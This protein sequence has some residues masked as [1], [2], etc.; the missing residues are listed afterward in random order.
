MARESGA[1]SLRRAQ[2][3]SHRVRRRGSLMRIE[4]SRTA[5]PA[6]HA[7]RGQ[8]VEG[9]EEGEPLGAPAG[10]RRR[11]AD[12]RRLRREVDSAGAG[13]CGP[14]ARRP[15]RAA[16][17]PRRPTRRLGRGRREQPQRVL[18]ARAPRSP[19]RRLARPRRGPCRQ[20]G[21]CGRPHFSATVMTRR[22]SS[23]VV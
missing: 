14:A 6:G 9:L 10:R 12:A 3:P 4:S 15:E 17:G 2:S 8:V 21:A 18:A 20:S 23:R 5:S 13:R 1:P 7:A 16:A 11:I 19:T 22:T